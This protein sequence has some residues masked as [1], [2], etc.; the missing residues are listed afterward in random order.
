[1]LFIQRKYSRGIRCFL[2]TTQGVP[3]NFTNNYRFGT[4]ATLLELIPFASIL[5]TFTNC[6]GAALWAADIEGNNTNM[7]EMKK[8]NFNSSKS[9]AVNDKEQ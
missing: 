8:P 5:F 1:M 2:Y 6:C 7:T 4:V 9:K 3:A